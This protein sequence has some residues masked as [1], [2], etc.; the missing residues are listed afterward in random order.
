MCNCLSAGESITDM[1]AFITGLTGQDGA[2]LAELLLS[3][4]YE[5]HGLIRRSSSPNLSRINHIKDSLHMHVGDVTDCAC[6]QDLITKLRPDEIYNLAAQSFVG[7]SFDMPVYTAQATGMGVLNVLEAIR[8]AGLAKTTRLY[9][10]SSSEMFGK[11]QSVPQT[12]STPFYP[13]S[14]YGVSKLFGHWAVVNFRETYGMFAVSAQVFNHESPL[15]GEE[16]V[17]RKI[18]KA[19]AAIYSGTQSCLSLGNLDARRDWTHAREVVQAMWL[20]LQQSEPE[21]YVIASG[22]SHT[23]RHFVELAFAA[24]GW[25]VRWQGTGL[26]EQGIL[27]SGS[28]QGQVVVTID[29]A[30]YR[31]CEV[32]LLVGD[33]SKAR[34]KLGWR[35]QI[36]LQ[37][38]VQEMVDSDVKLSRK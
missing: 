19:V 30:L 22:V 31:P 14:I 18:T 5:V 12:E 25:T 29:P 34:S 28:H 33:A 16:F 13:R 23:V 11:V 38:L 24:V 35:A 26:Q 32:D 7:C 6:L 4:G 37:Q 15:R 3:K 36:P 9:Q 20:M 10:A 27:S 1:K 2:L 17:T 21:D 8:T